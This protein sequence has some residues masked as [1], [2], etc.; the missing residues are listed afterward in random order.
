MIS[1]S[2]A[3][4]SPTEHF[5][6][7]AQVK[8]GIQITLI[9]VG[10]LLVVGAVVAAWQDLGVTTTTSL[11]AV[12]SGVI[13]VGLITLA[14]SQCKKPIQETEEARAERK[15]RILAQLRDSKYQ[16]ICQ[17]GGRKTPSF[18]KRSNGMWSRIDR[19]ET[20]N[21]LWKDPVTGEEYIKRTFI[22]NHWES[23]KAAD[24]LVTF[25]DQDKEA[26]KGVP[27]IDVITFSPHLIERL[28]EQLKPNGENNQFSSEQIAE[29]LLS[30]P[31]LDESA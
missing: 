28:D 18:V 10:I 13:L 4:I 23:I 22:P 1:E 15:T 27:A 14:L 6:L 2:S 31:P 24:Y 17:S 9:V 20:G 12:G 7:S 3:A 29:I 26:E 30:T 8:K 25:M 16:L 21:T 5:T 19:Y 11:A